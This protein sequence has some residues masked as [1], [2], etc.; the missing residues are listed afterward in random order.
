[1]DKFR[2]AWNALLEVLRIS[3]ARFSRRK[4][5]ELLYQSLET[6]EKMVEWIYE[7]RAKDYQSEFRKMVYDNEEE[8]L[9]V[10]GRL[11]DNSFIRDQKDDLERFRARVRSALDLTA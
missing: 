8:M 7:S 4:F 5:N 1:M 11:E 10:L 2:H 3:P 6:R 9:N